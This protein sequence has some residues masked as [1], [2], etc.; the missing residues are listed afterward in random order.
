MRRA[1][2]SLNLKFT[3]L[4]KLVLILGLAVPHACGQMCVPPPKGLVSWWTADGIPL[5]YFGRN[6]GLASSPVSYATGKVADAFS[7]NGSQY[8]QVPTDPSLEPSKITV[9]AW[10][11]HAG[12]PGEFKYIV[13][14][15]GFGDLAASYALYTGALGGLQFY[16][17]D[18]TTVT[19]SP[20]AGAAAVWDGNW[21]HVAGTFDGVTVRLFLDGSE[22][23]SGT[24]VTTAIAYGFIVNSEV[25]NDLFIGNYNPNCATC[26]VR[27]FTGD[28][29]EVEIFKR[30]LRPARIARIFAAGKAGKCLP[31]KIDIE[32]S[33]RDHQSWY[34]DW[35]S[36]S[37]DGLTISIL[38]SA[39]F[40]AE[41]IVQS[42][43]LLSLPGDRHKPSG[44]HACRLKDVNGDAFLDL[45]CDSHI[46][47]PRRRDDDAALVVTGQVLVP[48]GQRTFFGKDTLDFERERNR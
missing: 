34:F 1:K 2:L 19:L 43:L 46:D 37:K 23:G 40:H 13:S 32:S 35:H 27:S 21:H 42:T 36:R 39:A 4:G 31:A 30:A 41:D 16:I 44:V 47:Q 3:G 15:G 12:T 29:D 45:V 33:F 9:D 20:D 28:I 38:G 48:G 17:F 6:D 18:G 25:T 5:D 26:I 22:V 8:V 11:N 7:F 24:P 10:V 14:K